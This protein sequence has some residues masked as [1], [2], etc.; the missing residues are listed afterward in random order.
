M[1]DFNR[2]Y[3]LLASLHDTSFSV[4]YNTALAALEAK[5]F[6]E[7]IAI[8]EALARKAKGK[9]RADVCRVVGSANFGCKQWQKARQ[10]YEQ[11]AAMERNDAIVQYNCAVAS[12]NLG[13]MDAA[14]EYY[15]K[16]RGLSPSLSNKDIENRYAAAH[17]PARQGTVAVDSIDLL[18]NAAV[19]LQ[20]AKKNDSAE[21]IYKKI[22]GNN[23]SVFRAWNN[24]GT[25]YSA[26]GELSQ[27][28]ACFLK[29]VEKQ[30]DM[31]EAYANLVN[32]YLA[33]DSV[34]AAQRWI[35][36]GLGHNP[37]SEMLKEM[38]V[39]VKNVASKGRKR[40]R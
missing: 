28:L 10:W 23:G 21:A 36:K 22:L 35:I 12:Y 11:L 38:D 6:S 34:S 24:L 13:E 33:M 16:A 8:G 5:K 25:I 19:A 27:A 39:Q 40:K 7:A 14:W 18:Y 2:A 29:S 9:D 26:R 30:H 4:Q 31:P 15:Q 37:D 32:I 3:T 1:K 20:E 17:G